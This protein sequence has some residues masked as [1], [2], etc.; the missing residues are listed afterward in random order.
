[1]DEEIRM[2]KIK[3][4]QSI[5]GVG[6][7]IAKDLLDLGYSEVH[8]VVDRAVTAALAA[9]KPGAKAREVDA[10]ARGSSDVGLVELTL[11]GADGDAE[12]DRHDDRQSDAQDDVPRRMP[13]ADWTHEPDLLVEG[14][15]VL[16]AQR[17]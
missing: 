8:E 11:V 7:S 16:A 6:K 12:V 3:E 4:L 14:L 17:R 1:M 9:A 10:A 13:L 15:R 2:I 5:P